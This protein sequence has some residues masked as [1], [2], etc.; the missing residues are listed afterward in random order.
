MRV[1]GAIT[2]CDDGSAYASTI[3]GNQGNTPQNDS[4]DWTLVAQGGATGNTGAAGATGSTGTTGAT[5]QGS[6]GPTGAAGSGGGG[7]ASILMQGAGTP[8]NMTTVSGGP[9]G[10][11]TE[12]PVAGIGLL[13]VVS[14][15]GGAIDTT[16][17]ASSPP[18]NMAESLPQDGTITSISAYAST[19]TAQSLIGTTVTLKAQLW[20]STAPNNIF[21]PVPGAVV[22]LAPA[23]TGV[24]ALGTVSNGVTTG[25]SIPVT[26]QTRLMIVYSATAAGLNLTDSIDAYITSGLGLGLGVGVGAGAG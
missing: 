6:T 7:G 19:T 5:G 2:N 1:S 21:T 3:D 9:S 13:T 10:N 25:L 4:A 22:T 20:E 26:N 15:G 8:A 12:I 11:G 23:L 14:V 18:T 24:I 17:S 16:G